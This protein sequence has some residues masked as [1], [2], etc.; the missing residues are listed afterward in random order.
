M[1]FQTNPYLWSFHDLTLSE[2]LEITD[3]L[4]HSSPVV[5]PIFECVKI[6]V[7]LDETGTAKYARHKNDFLGVDKG[8]IVKRVKDPAIAGAVEEALDYVDTNYHEFLAL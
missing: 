7:K 6:Y 4:A 3:A 2:L 1:L 5:R 8:V